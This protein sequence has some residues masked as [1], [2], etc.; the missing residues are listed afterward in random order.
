MYTNNTF[1][2]NKVDE[3]GNFIN[4][5]PNSITNNGVKI[6]VVTNTLEPQNLD[7][8]QISFVDRK[9]LDKPRLLSLQQLNEI[10]AFEKEFRTKSIHD[11]KKQF[12]LL[13]IVLAADQF[14]RAPLGKISRSVFTIA[15][16]GTYQTYNYWMSPQNSLRLNRY[17]YCYFLLKKIELKQ[18]TEFRSD[19]KAYHIHRVIEKD[20][21]RWQVIPYYSR[22]RVFDNELLRSEDP[23]DVDVYGTY[24]MVGNVHE[25]ATFDDTVEHFPAG[26]NNSYILARDVHCLLNHNY[27]KPIDFYFTI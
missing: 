13:G 3:Y 20:C 1:K 11:I 15:L 17:D 9:Y 18:G 26:A 10:L 19:P 25:Y 22:E 23:D 5:F 12:Q 16:R 8:N 6:T 4:L 2:R 14:K 24:W 27:A 7:T 21:Y